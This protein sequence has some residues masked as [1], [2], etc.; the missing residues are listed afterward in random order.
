M[1]LLCNQELLANI[2][3]L[4]AI[5]GGNP[6]SLKYH[7]RDQIFD[8]L[9]ANVL[10]ATHLKYPKQVD[11]VILEYRIDEFNKKLDQQAVA[12]HGKW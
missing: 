7:L 8:T 5:A 3:I 11:N 9:S 2:L 10:A 1:I 6:R 4:T 12:G